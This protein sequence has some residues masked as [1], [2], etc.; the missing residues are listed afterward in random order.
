MGG[1]QLDSVGAGETEGEKVSPSTLDR[2]PSQIL[3][4]L[5]ADLSVPLSGG[6][7]LSVS[8]VTSISGDAT[9]M[10]VRGRPRHGFDFNMTL[11]WRAWLGGDEARE[12][13]GSLQLPDAS[14]DACQEEECQLEVEFKPDSKTTKKANATLKEEAA[15]AEAAK[16]MRKPLFAA[17]RQLDADMLA[18]ME[19][20]QT[21][22]PSGS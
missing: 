18:R 19:Q 3:Q 2:G 21:A 4:A 13:K 5:V 1:A 16:A 20:G 9:V 17:L 14:R 8:G 7:E 11:G 15:L 10:T 6:G 22:A 12:V